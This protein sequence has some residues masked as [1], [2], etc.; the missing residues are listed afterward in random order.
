MASNTNRVQT[1]RPV[2]CGEL[3]PPTPSPLRGSVWRYG[4]APLGTHALAREAEIL[5]GGGEI[6]P[7]LF[8]K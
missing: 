6:M 4:G 2:R 5:A 7:P 3:C 1:R 8:L